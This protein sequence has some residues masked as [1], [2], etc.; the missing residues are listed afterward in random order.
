MDS[1]ITPV[2]SVKPDPK[3]SSSAVNRL[4]NKAHSE[5]SESAMKILGQASNITNRQGSD[6]Q[7]L[8]SSQQDRM[9]DACRDASVFQNAKAKLLE[10]TALAKDGAKEAAILGLTAVNPVA[11]RAVSVADKIGVFDQGI[12]NKK[13]DNALEKHDQDLSD[14][15]DSMDMQ[16]LR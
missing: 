11:G 10:F 4:M 9:S 8:M 16:G 15:D 13:R 6:A 5:G 12:L 2:S 14:V 1:A 7:T 3:A